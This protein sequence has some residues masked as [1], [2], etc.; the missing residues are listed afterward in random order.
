M[1][2][3]NEIELANT[4]CKLGRLQDLY[5]AK[6]SQSDGNEQLREITLESL[7]RLINQLKEEI[8][9]AEIHQPAV[10]TPA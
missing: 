7:A 10:R 4:R 9:Y 2:L 1:K 5:H 3:L 6:E 8:T